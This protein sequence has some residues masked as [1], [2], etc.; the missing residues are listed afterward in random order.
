MFFN[1]FPSP[2][3]N[4][5]QLIEL[6][7]HEDIIPAKMLFDMYELAN[8]TLYSTGGRKLNT[9]KLLVENRIIRKDTN[10]SASNLIKRHF[11]LLQ[12]VGECIA[13]H[14]SKS[15]LKSKGD[16][17]ELER[18]TLPIMDKEYIGKET[19]ALVERDISEN[20]PLQIEDISAIPMLRTSFADDLLG[21]LKHNKQKV[22]ETTGVSWLQLINIL[23]GVREISAS[24]VMQY[25]RGAFDY[26]DG[27]LTFT[28]E[29]RKI[30][31]TE[32]L[33]NTLS[34]MLFHLR[35]KARNECWKHNSQLSRMEV[36]KKITTE[37][38]NTRKLDIKDVLKSKLK[39]METPELELEEE[40]WLDLFFVDRLGHYVATN[41][42]GAKK[43]LEILKDATGIDAY[44]D[45]KQSK[46]KI[47]GI[48]H[49]SLEAKEK[50]GIHR[51]ELL[52]LK[53]TAN[54]Q[55]IARS[56]IEPFE[57]SKQEVEKTMNDPCQRSFL[58]GWM[59]LLPLLLFLIVFE[60]DIATV[61]RKFINRKP[62]EKGNLGI[63]FQ[64]TLIDRLTVDKEA[65]KIETRERKRRSRGTVTRLC[66]EFIEGVLPTQPS[67]R[68][69]N[70]VS[71]DSRSI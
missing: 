3:I 23:S 66:P 43:L 5:K 67:N 57:L 13:G 69:I 9:D 28:S 54:S 1:V 7:I 61:A 29:P 38:F 68:P 37:E 32:E 24:K 8:T 64:Q 19:S 40:D 58:L 27:E 53:Q 48:K 59:A 33:T 25:L 26:K 65:A 30:S 50:R 45:E 31:D 41:K 10:L 47:I 20:D 71:L 56:F 60:N 6:G 49:L 22:C 17:G 11:M 70:V 63:E 44:E 42:K 39:I 18:L 14:F 55:L 4:K 35:E 36:D 16:I 12:T 62:K 52:R 15:E 51:S 2:V 34:K 21:Y 46:A